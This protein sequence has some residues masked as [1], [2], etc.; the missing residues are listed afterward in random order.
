MQPQSHG[1]VTVL[2]L[3]DPIE[4]SLEYLTLS[5]ALATGRFVISEISQSGSV[6]MLKAI[7]DSDQDVLLIDGEEV[8]GAKQNRVFNATIL[9]P[10]K[11]SIT[12]PVSCTEQGRWHY[13]S[14]DFRESGN[15]MS[16]RQRSDHKFR[17]LQSLRMTDSYAGNQGAV[18]NEVSKLHADLGTHSQTGAMSDAFRIRGNE[19]SELTRGFQ[20]VDGQVGLAA[21]VNGRLLGV[22][23]FS[24]ESAFARIFPKLIRS[25]AIEAMR[26]G[27]RRPPAA[28]ADSILGQY[29]QLIQSVATASESMHESIGLGSDYRY[30]SDDVVGSALVYNNEAA[31]MAFF[32]LDRFSSGPSESGFSSFRQRR[33]FRF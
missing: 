26:T 17:V 30:A 33:Q 25:Y 22:D 18:W 28:A 24:L 23:Y 1:A 12:L 21:A 19:I 20:L 3:V 16:H 15:F 14:K 7:N 29:E 27:P 8:A 4:R 32:A 6:P 11:S 2:P 10:A 31:H 13:A 9:V 5:E